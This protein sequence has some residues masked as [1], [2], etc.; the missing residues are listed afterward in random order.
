MGYNTT[1][2]VVQAIAYA[3]GNVGVWS[4]PAYWMGMSIT[5]DGMTI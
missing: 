5:G 2:N 1:D 4:T 3:S